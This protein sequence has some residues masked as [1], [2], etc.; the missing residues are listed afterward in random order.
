V[1]T[2]IDTF[3]SDEKF[4]HGD[5]EGAIKWIEGEVETSDEVLVDHGDFCAYV[6]A[7]GAV[8]LLE[9]AG[10]EHAKAMIQSDF[11]VSAIDIKD[12]SAKVVAVGGNFILRSGLPAV[13][14]WLMKLSET[15]KERF[16]SDA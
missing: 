16:F 8:S 11:M 15:V 1:F 2:S 12:P 6:G 9:K 3:S 5:V 13:E 14:K 10:C 7:Q 4:I